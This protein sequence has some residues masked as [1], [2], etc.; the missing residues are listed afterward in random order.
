MGNISTEYFQNALKRTEDARFAQSP[1]ESYRI[2][3]GLGTAAARQS[4]PAEAVAYLQKALEVYPEGDGAYAQLG[5]V[6]ITW[7]QN[8]KDAMALLDKAIQLSAVN[9][10][11]RDYMGVAF[12]N[13]GQYDQ[14]IKYFQEALQI[15]PDLQSA[16]QHLE[17][18]LHAKNP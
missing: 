3:L 10:F 1:Y 13:Q 7:G 6:L 14:A 5:G 8:Y 11:A 9:E 18:A 16:K 17:L 15:N 12:L 2:Y 4:M